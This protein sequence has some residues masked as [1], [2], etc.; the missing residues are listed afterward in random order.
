MRE[1]YAV[2]WH[3]CGY[4]MGTPDLQA[5]VGKWPAKQYGFLD[6]DGTPHPE[7]I[8]VVTEANRN[9]AR[10]HAEAELAPVAPAPP[11]G[12]GG[13]AKAKGKVRKAP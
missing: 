1:P 11:P 4:I 12:A 5:K 2:G 10:W 9:A 8:P 13:K 7:E 3:W 6:P